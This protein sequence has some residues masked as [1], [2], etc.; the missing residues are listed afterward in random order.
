MF[1]KLATG[2]SEKTRRPTPDLVGRGVGVVWGALAE[3]EDVG[4][5]A[6]PEGGA[7]NCS[8]TRDPAS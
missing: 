3:E 7:A 1:G 5:E 8:P 6:L 2:Q 4:V